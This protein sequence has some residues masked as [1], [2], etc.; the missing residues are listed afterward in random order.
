VSGSAAVSIAVPAEVVSTLSALVGALSEPV[1]L[2]GGWAVACR[3]RMARTDNRPTEDVDAM[4]RMTGRPH[5]AALDAIDAIQRD[6][7]HPCRLSGP[8][9]AL[10]VDLLADRPA[11][12]VGAIGRGIGDEVISVGGLQLLVPPCAALLARTSVE[13]RLRSLSDAKHSVVVRLPLAGALFAAKVANIALEH[14][15][16]AKRASDAEDAARLADAFGSMALAQDLGVATDG[17]RRQLVRLLA[18]IGASGL[19]AQSHISGYRVELIRLQPF[20]D[21]LMQRLGPQ[22][23]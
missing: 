10:S 1:V 8:T 3:L 9:L 12:V 11:D 14:R 16:P 21:D 15:A 18:A 13:V 23:L 6:A 22:P 7:A 19:T 5:K 2:V 17:E 20:V 4:L